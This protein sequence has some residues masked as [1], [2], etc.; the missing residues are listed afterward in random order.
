MEDLKEEM[1]NM[2]FSDRS[3]ELIMKS[4]RPST[5]HQYD[6]SL[7]KWDNFCVKNKVIPKEPEVPEVLDF[8]TEVHDSGVSYSTVGTARSALSA[9]VS[10]GAQPKDTVGE[11]T[12][13]ARLMKGVYE[14]KPPKAKYK[15]L[16]DVNLVF[17][18]IKTWG[19]NKDLSLEFMGYKTC[20]LLALVTAQRSQTLH[21][22]TV[23]GITWERDCLIFSLTK[24][25]KH[26]REG[27]VLDTIK[28]QRFNEDKRICPFRAIRDYIKATKADRNGED[29]LFISYGSLH[30]KV[31]KDT[32]ARWIK[33]TLTKAKV[34][35]G[36]FSAHSTRGA[37][38][39]KA[40]QIRVPL[41]AILSRARWTNCVTFARFYRRKIIKEVDMGS[42][43]LKNNVRVSKKKVRV[44]KKKGL[45]S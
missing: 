11:N 33:K 25:L 27:Q 41:D 37:A 19:E 28:V 36:V 29:Q 26:N 22:L 44:S 38:T 15:K 30:N 1:K 13:V 21:A 8:L 42:E 20:M 23:S 2:N 35:T 17:N 12:F 31:S 9:Y 4:W 10:F 18:L 5:I 39:S 24:L 40:A 16:W 34:N 43:L 32:I 7:K 14:E 3:S 45:K 6:C